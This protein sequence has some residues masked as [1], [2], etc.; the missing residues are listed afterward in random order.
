MAVLAWAAGVHIA[1]GA[2]GGQRT[3]SR[4]YLAIALC[5]IATALALAAP[6]TLAATARLGPI[7]NATRLLGDAVAML[8]AWCVLAMLAH[9]VGL[10]ATA[11]R[12]TVVAAGVLVACVAAMV[13]LLVVARTRF[14]IEFATDNAANALVVAFEALYVGYMCWGMVSFIWLI[15]RHAG[16]G[17]NRFM[18]LSLR[19]NIVAAGVGLAWAAWK[20]ANVAIIAVTRQPIADQA[21]ISE[22]LAAAVVG[23][24]AVGVALPSGESWVARI[25]ARRD[26]RSLAPLWRIVT[27]EVPQVLLPGNAPDDGIEYALYRRVIEIRDAQRVL[28]PYIDPELAARLAGVVEHLNPVRANLVIEASELASALA[29]HRAGHRHQPDLADVGIPRQRTTPDV[30]AEARWLARI[31]RVVRDDQHVAALANRDSRQPADPGRR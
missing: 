11:T 1:A 8:A 17:G 29:A 12:R 6:L 19:V 25:R 13:V 9:T 31:A 16:Q 28:R 30:H 22:L 2:R 18:R 21:S 23:L 20:V 15:R 5:A 27:A 14:T 10:P 4:V 26:Y 7:P 24:V 3:A